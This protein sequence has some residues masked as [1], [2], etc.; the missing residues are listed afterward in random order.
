MRARDGRCGI[1]KTTAVFVRA[2]R[3]NVDDDGTDNHHHHHRASTASGRG[4]TRG[5]SCRF[6]LAQSNTSVDVTL[7]RE[8]EGCFV[9][10]AEVT[11]EDEFA[12]EL[13]RVEEV[14]DEREDVEVEG[15]GQ[16]GVV[17]AVGRGQFDGERW[18]MTIGPAPSSSNTSN[19]S[20]SSKVENSGVR[21]LEFTLMGTSETGERV[22]LTSET[23]ER[24]CL[25]HDTATAT[26]KGERR[27]RNSGQGGAFGETLPGGMLLPAIDET[28][29]SAA[30]DVRTSSKRHIWSVAPSLVGRGELADLVV[31][32]KLRQRYES[33]MEY[34]DEY[35][36]DTTK[37]SWFDASLRLGIGVGL[38]TVLG[39]GLGLGVVV[40]GIRTLAPAR[41]S[42]RVSP[43]R[44]S[45]ELD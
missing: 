45:R 16:R 12:F 5:L 27:K 24:V 36:V 1:L 33:M 3:T 7:R 19:T 25:T 8:R 29:S 21:R 42:G 26:A 22:C 9:S 20:S 11:L 15:E 10:M 34:H 6:T 4:W 38:G 23:G 18:T 2:R 17:V 40:N 32:S 44:R 39:L 14:G 28:K 31:L 43:T 13:A 41:L 30:T 37:M 35:P